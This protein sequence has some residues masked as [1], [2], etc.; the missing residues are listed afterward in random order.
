M[1][2]SPS[3]RSRLLGAAVALSLI[4]AVASSAFPGEKK[5]KRVENNKVAATPTPSPGD[6]L[7]NLPLPVGHEAKGLVLPNFDADGHLTGK[8]E[9]GTAKRID[10]ENVQ[11]SAL[12]MTTFTDENAPDLQIEMSS[13]ILNLKTRVIS[14]KERTTVKRAD[15]DLVGDTMQYDTVSHRGTLIGHVK[16]VI[17]G[18]ARLR[19]EDETADE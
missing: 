12:K 7:T 16:M 9:A 11:F 6:S 4:L 8:L 17:T 15:I 13:S 5:K 19:T 14:S 2:R 3:G 1:L 10:Q 18:K